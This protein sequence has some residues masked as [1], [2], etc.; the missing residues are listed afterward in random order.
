MD[1]STDLPA[2]NFPDNTGCPIGHPEL[3]T[4]LSNLSQELCRPLVSLRMGF[5]LLLAD[6][7]P[8]ISP[9][10]RGHVETMVVLCDDLLRLTRTYLDYAGLVQGVRPFCFGTFTVGAV[11][12]EIDREFGPIAAARRIAWDCRLEGRD[13]SVTTDVTRCQQVF[14][15][16]LTNALKF[17][18]EGGEVRVSGRL[19]GAGWVVAVVDN[20]PGIPADHVDRVFEPF[21]RLSRDEIVRAEGTGLGLA[22]CRALVEQLG[23]EVHLQST[24]GKGTRVTVRL[25]LDASQATGASRR[26]S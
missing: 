19:E 9:D 24:V 2:P 5:D 23:G 4:I 3:R 7:V 12:R 21:Y 16:L 22:L 6:S 26:G 8:P 18:P 13:A 25:P 17:T 20:G 11:V 15:S 14:G 1:A 10:Q